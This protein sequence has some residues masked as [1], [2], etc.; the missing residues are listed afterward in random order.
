MS[1]RPF[2]DDPDVPNE[3]WDEDIDDDVD[4]DLDDEDVEMRDD[5]DEDDDDTSLSPSDSDYYAD[6]A[7]GRWQEWRGL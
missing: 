4:D 2:L 7:Q 6:R 5:P 1:E 3:E